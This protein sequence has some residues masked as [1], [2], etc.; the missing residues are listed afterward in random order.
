MGWVL[1]NDVDL[2]NPLVEHEKRNHKLKC[3]VQSP[4]SFFMS[5]KLLIKKWKMTRSNHYIGYLIRRRLFTKLTCVD[6]LVACERITRPNL[7]SPSRDWYKIDILYK[8]M[9]RVVLLVDYFGKWTDEKK[10]W[11]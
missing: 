3:L 8:I 2:L 5:S 10:S 6:L 1:P 9:T 11:R 4:N 7:G